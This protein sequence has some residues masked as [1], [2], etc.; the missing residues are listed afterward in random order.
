MG[1]MPVMPV[2]IAMRSLSTMSQT[3]NF[4][5]FVRFERY[6][7][8][9]RVG[10]IC[11]ESSNLSISGALSPKHLLSSSSLFMAFATIVPFW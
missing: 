5:P 11:G 10:A 4:G 9:V 6:V 3:H 1:T 7:R 8:F 2:M